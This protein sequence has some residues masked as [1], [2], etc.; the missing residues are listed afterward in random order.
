MKAKYI[1]NYFVLIPSALV[2]LLI[3]FFATPIEG[4][5][6]FYPSRKKYELITEVQLP[7]YYYP[8]D[9]N[10]Q[11]LKYQQILIDQAKA[12]EKTLISIKNNLTRLIKKTDSVETKL[13]DLATRLT[14]LENSLN[15]NK[16]N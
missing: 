11:L 5:N 1:N 9:P 6:K 4:K 15:T 8:H 7:D 3:I 10:S 2:V 14:L 13:N 16:S 12:N